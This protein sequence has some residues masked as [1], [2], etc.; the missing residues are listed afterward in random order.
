MRKPSPETANPADIA[1]EA[2]Q[3]ICKQMKQYV[4]PAWITKDTEMGLAILLMVNVIQPVAKPLADALEEALASLRLAADTCCANGF[5]GT[6]VSCY[7]AIRQVNAALATY[8]AA[9][10]GE[11]T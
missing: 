11:G 1:K 8:R 5:E 10:E 3:E 7:A 6:A 9:N 2:A 4:N